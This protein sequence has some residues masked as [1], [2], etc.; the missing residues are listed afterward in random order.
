MIPVPATHHLGPDQGSPVR[1]RVCGKWFRAGK[2]GCLTVHLD[3]GCCHYGDTEVSAP[4][5]PEPPFPADRVTALE[6]RVTALEALIRAG[7]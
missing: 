6:E 7:R 5:N 3:G 1:C 4:E 2:K